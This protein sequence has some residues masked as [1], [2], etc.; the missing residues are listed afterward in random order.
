MRGELKRLA[1]AALLILLCASRGSE[2]GDFR[3]VDVEGLRILFDSEWVMQ[4]APGYVPVRL[5]ITNL[6]D[7]RV[8]DIVADGNRYHRFMSGRPPRVQVLQ[9]LRMARGDRVRITIPVPVMDDSEN[10]RFEI[11]EN[12]RTLEAFAYQGFRSGIPGANASAL[13]VANS[14]SAFGSVADSLPRPDA[15]GRTV[16]PG[17]RTAIPKHD[18]VLDPSR[19]P[20]NWLGYTSVRAVLIGPDEWLALDDPQRGAL[21]TWTACGGDLI[22]VSADPMPLIG[23]GHRAPDGQPDGAPHAYFFGRVHRRSTSSIVSAGLV[24]VLADAEKV[25]DANF[26]LPAN[27]MGYWS[28]TDTRGFR[29]TI[30]GVHGVPTRAYLSI[31]VVF[32]LLIGPINYWLLRRGQRLVLFVLTVPVVSAIFIVLLAGYVVAGEGF[33]VSGRAATF[34]MID[35]ARKQAVTRGSASLYAAGMTPAGGLRFPRDVAVYALGS[36]G[37]GSKDNQMLDLTETQQFSSGIIHARAPTNLEE[38]AFRSARERLTFARDGAGFTVVNGLGARIEHLAYRHG[39]AA[40][41]L[42]APLA[43]GAT[44]RLR[45]GATDATAF[46]PRDLPALGRFTF[47]FKAQPDN[48]YLAVLDQSPFWE[49]GAKGVIER[50]SFHLVL[51]WPDGQP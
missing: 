32:S 41:T 11:Q 49:P 9:T 2:A 45:P 4:T 33:H 34:T 14:S 42:D 26:G 24:S 43:A 38:I 31:L 29:L 30:P 23:G 10:Y 13:I 17:M 46:V 19:L 39:G 3:P 7:T 48:T 20:V 40:Y 47:L 35:E 21:L 5:D 6:G 50:G 8:I 36:D 12:G 22:F 25:Q 37:T 1:F 28:G 51:G 27:R 18:F 15:S 16:V 44:G